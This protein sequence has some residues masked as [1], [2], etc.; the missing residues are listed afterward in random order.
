MGSA[1]RHKLD[2]LPAVRR[3]GTDSP[4]YLL[5]E[6]LFEPASDNFVVISQENAQHRGAQPFIAPAGLWR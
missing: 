6:Q 5:F 3:L 2:S 1:L 4:A